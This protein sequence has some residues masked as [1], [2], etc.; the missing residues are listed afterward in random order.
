MIKIAKFLIFIALVF[1]MMSA[2]RAIEAWQLQL[3]KDEQRNASQAAPKQ[4]VVVERETID[5]SDVPWK[6]PQ[7][8]PKGKNWTF[9]LFTSPT[10]L[11]EGTE[12]KAT[13]PWMEKSQSTINFEIIELGK[14][15]YPL[16]FSG[17][18]SQP[19]VDGKKSEDYSFSFML[20]DVQNR[21]SLQVQL[22]QVIERY[23]VE[24]L[25]FTEKGPN[26]E[27]QGYPQLKV[28]DRNIGREIILTPEKRYYDQ[29]FVIRLRSKVDEKE[30][31]LSH[32]DEEFSVGSD[33]YVLKKIDEEKKMLEFSQKMGKDS[34]VFSL[35][36]VL[37]NTPGITKP[38]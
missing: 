27:V 17:Y 34:C 22:G 26:G 1:I 36:I 35:G 21:E 24:I 32:V 20:S 7:I 30:F 28:M 29:L 18:F 6:N 12:F 23:D 33:Q 3:R 14:K 37:G 10:I 8:A 13:L 9:D 19:M 31:F 5:I 38:I 15:V 2:E 11:R 16:Q 25:S 4:P